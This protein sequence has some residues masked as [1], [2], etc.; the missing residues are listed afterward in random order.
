MITVVLDEPLQ[1]KE[2][3]RT[4]GRRRGRLYMPDGYTKWKIRVRDKLVR[5]FTE[6]GVTL[7][8]ARFEDFRIETH[9]PCRHDGDNLIGALFDAGLPNRKKGFAGVWVDDRVS[10]IPRF[11]FAHV[12]DRSEFWLLEMVL[13]G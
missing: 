3:P 8:I 13:E 11:H 2:R 5:A 4:D 1:G 7:P 9:G 12:K 10:R 6:A